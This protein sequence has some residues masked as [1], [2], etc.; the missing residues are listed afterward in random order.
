MLRK[1]VGLG[2]TDDV[3]D[4]LRQH[5]L[6]NQSLYLLLILINHCTSGGGGNFFNPYREAVVTFG[7][8]TGNNE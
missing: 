2:K 1:G 5:N 3:L 6:A 8:E 7:N 4:G